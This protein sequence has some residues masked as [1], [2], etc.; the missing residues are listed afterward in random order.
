MRDKRRTVIDVF[1]GAGGLSLGAARAGFSLSASVDCDRRAIGVHAANF[2][3]TQHVMQD[4]A[5]VSGTMLLQSAGL[6]SGQLD[7]LIGGPPCQGFSRIGHRRIDD[8]RNSFFD[9]FFRLVAETRPKFYIAEN[10]LGILDPPFNEIRCHALDRVVRYTNL[11]AMVLKASDFGSA[12]SRERVFFIGYLPG[13]CSRLSQEDFFTHHREATTVKEAFCGLPTTIDPS[14]QT[15]KDGWQKVRSMPMGWFHMK[16]SSD[17]PS[18]QRN[19]TGIMM[20]TKHKLVSGCLGTRHS[21]EVVR[22]FKALKPGETDAVSR[23][24]RLSPDGLCP[25]LRSGTGPDR[26]SFQALRPIHPSEPR[27]ITPREAARLQGFPDWFMFDPT[28]WHSFRLIGNSVSPIMA[29]AILNVLQ[30][31]G[32]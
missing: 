1:C 21:A 5:A 18:T 2:P 23:A 24:V 27:V 6:R 9:H 3:G 31:K 8:I 19:S 14:W 30:Q 32:R 29:E 17:I 10:V 20:L 13:E 26:G 28:K 25:T 4:V 15:E 11:P 16:M 22:R 12:T 7:G